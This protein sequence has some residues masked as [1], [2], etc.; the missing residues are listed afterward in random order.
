MKLLK[1]LGIILAIIVAVLIVLILAMPTKYNV[2]RSIVIDAP[3]NIVYD[4]VRLFENFVKWS[5]WSA[6]DPNMSYEITQPDGTV[7]SVYSWSGNDSVGIGSLEIISITDDRID[8]RLTF[9]A[10]WEAHDDAYYTFKDTPEGIQVTWG[11][12]GNLPRPTNIFGLFMDMENM[13]GGDYEKGLSNLKARVMDYVVSHTKRGYLIN[14]IDL[15]PRNY[16]SYRAEVKFSEMQQFYSTHFQGIMKLVSMMDLPLAGGPSGMFYKYDMEN[17]K[18]D[19]AAGIPVNGEAAVD[20]YTTI[21]VSGKAL[22]ISYFGSY[23][24]IAEAHYAMDD[25]MK[26]NNMALNE[27]VIEEYITDP[28]GEPDTSKWLT[29]IYYL[30]K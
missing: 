16:I 20:G 29:N 15:S 14:I 10:P 24:G 19:M 25:L 21:P 8:Q 6:L 30:I 28:V 23:S 5:P 18:A 26:E 7:G 9:S 13:I 27:L 11:L 1:I 4:Q 17:M 12:D 22:H 3:G 2:E